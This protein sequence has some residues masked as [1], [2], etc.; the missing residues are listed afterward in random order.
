MLK[1]LTKQ[2]CYLVAL[3]LVAPLAFME[4]SARRLCGRDFWFQPHG[5]LLS[6][7]PGKTGSFLRN[8]YLHLTL[9]KCPLGCYFS[10]GTL[11]T[12]SEAE[13]GARV[14]TGA[15]CMIGLATIEDDTMLADHVYILSGK[16]Q[17]GTSDP[18]VRF[19]DQPRVFTRIRIGRNCWVGTNTVIMADI[20]DDCVIGA[21]SVVTKPVPEK[22][23]AVGNPARV[24]RS[25]YL[26]ASSSADD[27]GDLAGTV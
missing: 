2:A 3:G 25:T 19:Q 27:P 26:G 15:H 22:C 24:L 9:H 11:F 7:V 4:R 13:V 21:G 1:H 14:Y 16:H 6:L 18:T 17:H 23:V 10:F 20:G 8:A 12:H 5:Q